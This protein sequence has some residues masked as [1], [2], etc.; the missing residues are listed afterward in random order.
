MRQL[1]II[2][3]VVKDCSK[4]HLKN[5]LPPIGEKVFADI[6]SFCFNK[7]LALWSMES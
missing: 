4:E 6:I 2:E 7:E 1:V 3:K 5:I